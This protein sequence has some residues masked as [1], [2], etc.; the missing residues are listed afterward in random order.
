MIPGE[1]LGMDGA[2]CPDCYTSL[3]LR[4]CKSNAGW[5][6]GYWCDKDGPESRETNYFLTRSEAEEAMKTP[7]KFART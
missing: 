6:L 3:K 5:Y 1:C 4:V 2:R 7:E